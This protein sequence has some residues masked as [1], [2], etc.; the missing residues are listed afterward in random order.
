MKRDYKYAMYVL[1]LATTVALAAG[2]L[3]VTGEPGTDDTRHAQLDDTDVELLGDQD[4]LTADE[5]DRL[6][7][8]VWEN[9][10]VRSYFDDPDALTFEVSERTTYDE[11]AGEFVPADDAVQVQVSPADERLPYAFVTVD[12]DEDTASLEQGFHSVDDVDIEFGE[13]THRLTDD[14]RDRIAELLLDDPDIEWE[15]KTLLDEPDAVDASVVDRE[16][17]VVSVTLA[18][19][20][21]HSSAVDADVDL[22]SGSVENLSVSGALTVNVSE[23][24]SVT[25]DTEADGNGTYVLSGNASETISADAVTN[26]SVAG[27]TVEVTTPNETETSVE[28][29]GV[30]VSLVEHRE[31]LSEHDPE[32]FAALVWASEDVRRYFDDPETIE[33]DVKQDRELDAETGEFTPTDTR[34]VR[35]TPTDDR[36]PSAVAVVDPAAETV[37]VKRGL[38]AL[39]SVDLEFTDETSLVTDA[40]RDL[41]E[42]VVRADDAASYTIQSQ[43]DDPDELNATV[44]AATGDGPETVTVELAP[45]DV[46]TASVSVTVDLENRTVTRSF[47]VFETLDIEVTDIEDGDYEIETAE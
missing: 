27:T 34:T 47:V 18:A 32:E 35:V 23:S 11:D 8:L 16:G 40:D 30:T 38:P 41:I 4:A 37:T 22:A 39:E 44:T 45:P 7:H 12:L 33:M 31:S 24:E 5:R 46:E 42:E 3:V 6:P 43:F 25:V 2:V 13:G 15:I 14:E 28:L 1:A 19:S 21:G 29:D 9:E 17:D 36:L 10:N 26:E 20:D